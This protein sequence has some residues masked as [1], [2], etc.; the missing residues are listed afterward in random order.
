M[1]VS[2]VA[3]A[4]ASDIRQV[5]SSTGTDS[6]IFINWV[7]QIHKN[8]LHTSVYNYVIRNMVT[9]ETAVNTAAYTVAT[10]V[11]PRRLLMVYDRTFERII[12]PVENLTAPD[13]PNEDNPQQ[14]VGMP[15]P[16]ISAA[17]SE[18]WPEYYYR[19][20]ASGSNLELMLFPAPQKTA[21]VGTYEIYYE[22]QVAT[23]VALTDTLL[24]PD[25]ALDLMVAGVNM[26]AASYLKLSEDVGFWTQQYEQLKHGVAV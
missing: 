15:K 5:L 4:V 16:M 9:F 10:P 3:N 13:A 6:S 1:L 23:V 25:D 19:V 11:T 14:P 12:M 26:R 24:T 8:V 2:D 22:K 7:D 18:Q 20:F 17:T 21:F